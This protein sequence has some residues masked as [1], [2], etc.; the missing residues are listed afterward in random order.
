M[1]EYTEKN[2]ALFFKV[3]ASP[4]ASR[5]EIVGEHDGAL[6]DRLMPAPV[7]GAANDELIRILARKFGVAR[8]HVQIISGHAS[9]RKTVSVTRLD[10]DLV[11]KLNFLA[12]EKG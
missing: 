2:G 11:Q 8:D 6:R 10:A 3:V 12:L 4:R 9:R 7:A 5:T 1:I